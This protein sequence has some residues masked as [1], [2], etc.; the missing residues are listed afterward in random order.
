MVSRLFISGFTG[1]PLQTRR[2]THQ[3]PPQDGTLPMLTSKTRQNWKWSPSSCRTPTCTPL[4]LSSQTKNHTHPHPCCSNS[5]TSRNTSPPHS[6]PYKTPVLKTAD[7]QTI[8]HVST[9]DAQ[10][11]SSSTTIPKSGGLPPPAAPHNLKPGRPGHPPR[12]LNHLPRSTCLYKQPCPQPN[13]CALY[14]AV[15]NGTP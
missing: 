3:R 2:H 13:S 7:F 12:P 4:N 8:V 11:S 10:H 5:R 6:T 14:S 9:T 1:S 15:R